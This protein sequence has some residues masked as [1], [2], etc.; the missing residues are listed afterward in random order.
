MPPKKIPKQYVPKSL[1]PEDKKKQIKSIKEGKDRPKVDSFKSKRS[2]HVIKFEKRYGKKITDD[3]W[4]GKNLLRPAGIK[5]ILKKGAG[6]YYSS[7]S[8][9]NQTVASWSR[10]RLASALTG[11]AAAKVDKDI[12]EKYKVKK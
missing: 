7:G 1:T 10:A 8:R 9:P 11:G 3:E 12:L 5:Q 6:A 4:I 2:S